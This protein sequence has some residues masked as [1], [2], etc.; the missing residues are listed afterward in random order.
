M[1]YTC[2]PV[3]LLHECTDGL[4]GPRRPYPKRRAHEG[5]LVESRVRL[6]TKRLKR[7]WLGP[8]CSR[9]KVDGTK[10]HSRPQ[11]L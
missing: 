8:G 7:S 11:R 10:K 6:R 2:S 3:E 4:A 9:D 1:A 5:E